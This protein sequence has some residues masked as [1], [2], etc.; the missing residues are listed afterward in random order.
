MLKIC[1]GTIGKDRPTEFKA[2]KNVVF[3][4]LKREKP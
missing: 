1:A 2:G 3:M 4:V